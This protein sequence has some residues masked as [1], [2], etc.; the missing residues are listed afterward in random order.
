[1]LPHIW[2]DRRVWLT[3][4]LP[5]LAVLWAVH[6]ALHAIQSIGEGAGDRVSGMVSSEMSRLIRIDFGF[7]LSLIAA[8]RL[9]C[10]A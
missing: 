4:A 6:C 5:V 7:Y 3:L 9:P 1:M 8:S 10:S 2:R